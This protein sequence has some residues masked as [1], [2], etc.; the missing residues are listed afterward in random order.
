MSDD[1]P[2]LLVDVADRV[3]TLTLN[4]PGA[5]NA[6]SRALM[7]TLWDAVLAAGDDPEVDA[8]V[9][10]G[11][12]P[13]FCAGLDLKEVAG[14]VPASAAPRGPARAPSATPTV[15]TGSCRSSRSP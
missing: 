2:A 7:F 4:R 6:L 3:A 9:V 15:S 1:E 5:R 14:E 12:D 10:T 8:V 13:A 11:A